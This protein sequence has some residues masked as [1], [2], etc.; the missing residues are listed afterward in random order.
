MWLFF[1]K[2]LVIGFSL[3]LPVGPIALLC[4]RRTLAKGNLSGL[5]TGLG[6]ATADGVY[7]AVA[8][9]GITV[10]SNF[11]VK[12]SFSLRLL[13]GG[14]LCYLGFRIFHSIPRPKADFIDEVGLVKDYFST[15]VLTLTN[16]ITLLAFAAVFAAAGPAEAKHTFYSTL[17]M[18]VGVV[19]G[20]AFWWVLLTGMVSIF[21]G[22]I[23]TSGILIINKISGTVICIFGIV[24]L[25][26]IAF[27]L[28]DGPL[29]F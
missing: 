4:I 13:G 7:G 21:H 14:F 28:L 15:F 8:G 19:F 24:V 5:F 29:P 22:K 1:V 16:P 11:L 18:V 17:V 9:F 2:G 26:T 10:I 20:S 3:A 12:H 6:A 23:N 27:N 25:V